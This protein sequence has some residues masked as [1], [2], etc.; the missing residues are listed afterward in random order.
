VRIGAVFPTTELGSDPGAIRA[1]V[2]GVRDL[3]FDHLTLHDHV[4]GA[5]R[6][7]YADAGFGIYF[8]EHLFHEVFVVAG[9]IAAIAPELELATAIVVAP[10]R[11]TALLAKQAA[12]VDVLTGGKL[13]L[14][15]GTGKN[16]VEYG[17]LGMP[18]T[19]RARRFEEQIELLRRLWQ[20]PVVRFDGEWHSVDSAGIN[21]RPVQRPIPI[22]IGAAS[23]PAMRRAARL[24]DGFITRP[25]V[26][27]S[28]WTK[29]I[30]Q[31][32]EWV[33]EAG[34]DPAAFG[35][36]AGLRVGED[37]GS[38]VEHWRSLGATH[39]T[40]TAENGGIAGV[41]A[42]LEALRRVREVV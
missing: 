12:E 23:E 33:R 30:A 32:R 1:F 18:F 41:D 26:E 4:L 35:I 25:P 31:L 24:A 5:D 38:T 21:P 2:E 20:E 22:W 16:Y 17:A 19:G 40:F 8:A 13:R 36:E 15:L 34:R 42:H 39:L 9:F 14:G 11:Q 10:Q 7:V 29:K 27:G 6:A 3:G 37:M 28:D